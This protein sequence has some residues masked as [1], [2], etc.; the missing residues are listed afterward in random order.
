MR[1]SLSGSLEP[2]LDI[3]SDNSGILSADVLLGGKGGVIPP[4]AYNAS[5]GQHSIRAEK[6]GVFGRM[7]LK[8]REEEKNGGWL[9]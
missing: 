2:G 8:K 9:F 3:V 6:R 5:M 7:E 1:R 4:R